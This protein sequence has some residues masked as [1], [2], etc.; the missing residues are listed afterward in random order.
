MCIRDSVNR[1]DIQ[2]E[3]VV[4]VSNV[5]NEENGNFKSGRGI[6]DS[7]LRLNINV[8]ENFNEFQDLSINTPNYADQMESVGSPPMNF[9]QINCNKPGDSRVISVHS[10]DTLYAPSDTPIFLN[11]SIPNDNNSLPIDNVRARVQ[12]RSG[13]R[14]N[15]I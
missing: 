8:L 9:D 2:G 10:L 12:T 5:N 7:P 13:I 3:R 4:E 1:P 6:R 15:D 14:N 11:E